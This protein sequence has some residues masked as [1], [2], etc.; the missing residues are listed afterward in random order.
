MHRTTAP[1]ERIAVVGTT[2]AGKTTLASRLANLLGYPHI[3]L[4]ALNWGPGWTPAPVELF[5]ERA[6]QQ[7]AWDRWVCDGNYSVL[8]PIIW[9]R[10]DTL[11]WLDYP[12]VVVLWRLWRRTWRRA[13]TQEELWNGNRER[14][15]S[16][17]LSRDSLFLWAL[18]THRRRRR[19]YPAALKDPAY[20]HLQAIRLRTPQ[21]TRRWLETLE[22]R[23]PSQPG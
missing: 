15:R 6:A 3:E 2:G 21:A 8:R 9:G 17:F 7:A 10:A 18:Q 4:D 16:A 22:K 5:R 19:E 20:A 1:G 23:G 14:F 13:I 11:V 12:L